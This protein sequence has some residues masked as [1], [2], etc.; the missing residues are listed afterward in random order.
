MV[1]LTV[2]EYFDVQHFMHTRFS[3]NHYLTNQSPNEFLSYITYHSKYNDFEW[4][5]QMEFIPF[6][7]LYYFAQTKPLSIPICFNAIEEK[8]DRL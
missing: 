1:M 6:Q 2:E 3:P 4:E 5:F 8:N 7:K